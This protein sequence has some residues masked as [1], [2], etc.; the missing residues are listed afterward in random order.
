MKVS[1]P[2]SIST[3]LSSLGTSFQTKQQLRER[4][5]L[6]FAPM[7]NAANPCDLD[8]APLL[9]DDYAH[10]DEGGGY[11]LASFSQPAVPILSPRKFKHCIKPWFPGPERAFLDLMDKYASSPFRKSML[12][13]IACLLWFVLFSVLTYRGTITSPVAHLGLPKRP[14]CTSSLW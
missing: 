10:G 14:A 7:S 1:L 9:A 13:A 6:P 4:R 11:C 2:P 3:Q 5:R 12:V 8:A